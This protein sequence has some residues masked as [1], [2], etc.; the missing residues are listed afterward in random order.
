MSEQ[1]EKDAARAWE[2]KAFVRYQPARKPSP[3]HQLCKREVVPEPKS[4][5][6]C[7]SER[8][9]KIGENVIETLEVIQT[10][11]EQPRAHFTPRWD[12]TRAFTHRPL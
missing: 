7:G 5:A 9:S 8:M 4:C 10:V 12:F 2:V 1:A 3:D 11:R 6:C